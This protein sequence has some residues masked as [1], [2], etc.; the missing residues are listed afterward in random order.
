VLFW[1][2]DGYSTACGHGTLAVALW[3]VESG[4]IAAPADGEVAVTIAVPSGRVVAA[5]RPR[6]GAVES[7]A[8][9]NVR[10]FVIAAV[11]AGDVEVDFATAGQ[12]TRSRPQAA[13]DCRSLGPLH[14]RNVAIFADGEVDRSLTVR[15]LRT[16]STAGRR[17]RTRRRRDVA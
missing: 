6:G 1:H 17:R 11:A 5:V 10:S 15:D 13:S 3:A 8:F 16:N 9:R 7:V 14:Y 4:R 2:K 12:S